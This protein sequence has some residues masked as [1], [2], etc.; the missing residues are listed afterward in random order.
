M[1]TL[2]RSALKMAADTMS[3]SNLHWRGEAAEGERH[4]EHGDDARSVDDSKVRKHI[5][6]DTGA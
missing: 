1:F 2:G 5:L 4:D 3:W 6:S